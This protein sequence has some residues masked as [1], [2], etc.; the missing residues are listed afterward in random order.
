MPPRKTITVSS[1]VSTLLSVLCDEVKAI[2]KEKFLALY[3]FGSFG[4]GDFRE[5]SSD[6]DFLVLVASPLSRAEEKQLQAMHNKLRLTKFGDRLEGEYV[7]VTALHSKGVDGAVA[8]CEGGVLTLKVPSQVS[9]ENILDIKQNAIVLYGSHPK[10]FLPNV[11]SQSVEEVMRDYLRDNIDELK[12]SQPKNLNKLSSAVLNTCRTLYTLKTGRI[13][14]KSDGAIW[15][16]KVLSPEWKLLIRRSL[17]VRQ[18]KI[19]KNDATFIA[20]AL[21][22]FLTYALRFST[23]KSHQRIRIVPEVSARKS[24]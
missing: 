3:V 14:S 19:R 5:H 10:N 4:M 15:A 24:C 23:S 11:S 21:P 20:A 8:R 16:L 9:A 13:T 18:G 6:I 1:Q 12:R 17:A 22:R 7:T 2:L